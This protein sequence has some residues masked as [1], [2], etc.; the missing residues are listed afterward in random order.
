MYDYVV[1]K[2][3]TF[4]IEAYKK[5][6]NINSVEIISNSNDGRIHNNVPGTY[7]VHI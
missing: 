5:N 2:E 4:E 7:R 6:F 1:Q 3:S